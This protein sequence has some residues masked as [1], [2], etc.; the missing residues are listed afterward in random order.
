MRKIFALLFV[1]LLSCYIGAPQQAPPSSYTPQLISFP[2]APFGVCYIY[3]VGLNVSNGN[4]YSCNPSNRTW[5]RLS[6]SLPAGSTGDAQFAN[7]TAFS[8]ANGIFS[9]STVSI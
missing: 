8:N 7:G 3:Q 4:Y 9:G 6:S 1:V 5:V 2:G